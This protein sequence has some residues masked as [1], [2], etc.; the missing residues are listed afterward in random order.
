MYTSDEIKSYLKLKDSI[1]VQ[2]MNL[3]IQIAQIRKT[4]YPIGDYDWYINENTVLF[5]WEESEKCGC[6]SG[7]YE[8]E[9][10]TL[11]LI[12][13]KPLETEK[14]LVKQKEESRRLEELA[15]KEIEDKKKEDDERNTYERLRNKYEQV[16]N[17]PL[18]QE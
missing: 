14:I 15:E 2:C 6:C 16:L 8:L 12:C 7:Y 18:S 4:H 11:Y 10:P 5:K 9:F 3:A 1:Q 17:K 13:D